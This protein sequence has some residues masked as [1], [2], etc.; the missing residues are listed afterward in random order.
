MDKLMEGGGA[1]TIS[2]S[3][4]IKINNNNSSSSKLEALTGMESEDDEIENE[5]PTA[6]DMI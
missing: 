1:K 6:W 3:Q 2:Q 5:E 4:G